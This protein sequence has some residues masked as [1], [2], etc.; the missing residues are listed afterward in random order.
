ML[1]YHG[2]ESWLPGGYLGVEVFFVLSGYL[3]TSLLLAEWA[4]R[5]INLGRFWAA[6]GA[7]VAAGAVRPRVRGRRPPGGRRS[8]PSRASFR[9]RRHRHA[10]LFRQLAANLLFRW[11]LAQTALVS[12]LQHT[13][14]LAIEE[15]FYLVWPLFLLGCLW[16]GRTVARLGSRA[17]VT[18]RTEPAEVGSGL[19]GV[20]ALSLIGA[21][22]SGAAMLVLFHS[23]AG[24]DRVYYGTDTRAHALFLGAALAIAMFMSK[25][26]A[27]PARRSRPRQP[28]AVVS[29]VCGCLG[30]LGLLGAMWAIPGTSRSLY[31]GGFFVIDV[32][33]VAVLWSVAAFDCSPLSPVL[34][35]WPLRRLGLI[36][37]GVYLWHFPLFLWLDTAT[38]GLAGVELLGLRMATSV[39]AASFSFVLVEEPVRRRRLGAR[40]LRT[41]GPAGLSAAVAA[42]MVAS[43]AAVAAPISIDRPHEV[44]PSTTTRGESS[45]CGISLPPR[46]PVGTLRPLHRSRRSVSC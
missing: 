14:S 15:Q 11:L 24:L 19:A 1:L 31:D 16:V 41:L 2:G 20:L 17:R 26:S 4:N 9:I 30:A 23:G 7:A 42:V 43:S 33:V 13:W 34:R 44:P 39:A 40:M 21:C 8:R 18:S 46:S 28:G 35:L 12:P 10:V 45:T 38:T 25:N 6:A 37:Y 36:S 27:R 32:A 22:A 5:K 29:H 3:I